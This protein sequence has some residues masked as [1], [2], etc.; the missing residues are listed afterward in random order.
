MKSCRPLLVI[1]LTALIATVA[2]AQTRP[3]SERKSPPKPA[4][5]DTSAQTEAKIAALVV[6]VYNDDSSMENKTES[7]KEY[8]AKV[9]EILKRMRPHRI[10]YEM[11]EKLSTHAYGDGS[12]EFLATAWLHLGGLPEELSRTSVGGEEIVAWQ[13]KHPDGS[14]LIGTF[15]NLQ[16]VSK[17]QSGL[18]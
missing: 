10:T 12:G 11:Y 6:W 4:A 2:Q 17:A 5:F 7:R 15:R 9:V 18:R 8:A 13:W 16:L 3:S 14:N 1:L